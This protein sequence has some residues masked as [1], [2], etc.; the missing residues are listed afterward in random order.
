MFPDRG[1]DAQTLTKHADMAMYLAKQE[2]RND[3]R[4]FSSNIRSQSIGRLPLE[5]LPQL[6]IESPTLQPA[7]T[8]EAGQRKPRAA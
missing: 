3:L 5:S 6:T 4:F 7:T 1:D 2:G 8:T